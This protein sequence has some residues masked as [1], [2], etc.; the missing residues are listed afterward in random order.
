MDKTGILPVDIGIN[1]H[2]CWVSDDKYNCTYTLCNANLL[3]FL[4]FVHEE[5]D[6]RLK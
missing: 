2:D 6:Q 3:R 4:K 5:M 1:I